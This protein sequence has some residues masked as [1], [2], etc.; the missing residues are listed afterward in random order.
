MGL[1]LALG[2]S[3]VGGVLIGAFVYLGRSRD[4]VMD[5]HTA[6]KRCASERTHGGSDGA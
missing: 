1:M 5:Y 6:S 2:S 3:L 4:R